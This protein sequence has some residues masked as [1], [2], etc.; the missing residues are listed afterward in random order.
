MADSQ[1][2]PESISDAVAP[3][4]RSRRRFLTSMAA[5]GLVLPS[6]GGWSAARAEDP[7]GSP[8]R[9][10]KLAWNAG[11]ACLS[12]VALADRDNIFDTENLKVELVNFSGSTDQLLESIATGKADAAVGM[13]L[14]WLKPL[15]QGFDVKITAGLHGG[16]LRL[17]GS[18][19]AGAVDLTSLKGKTIAVADMGSPAKNFFSVMLVKQG[20]D[21]VKD[22]EW[23]QYPGNLLGLAIEKGEAHALADNDPITWP[24]RKDPNLVELATNL[25][26]EYHDRTC[27][28]IGIRGSLLR[29]N[30][31]A[32]ARLTRALFHAWHVTAAAPEAAAAAFAPYAPKFSQGDL[33]EM[34]HSHN[35]QQQVIGDTLRAQIVQYVEELKVAQVFKPTTDAAKFAQRVT[36]DVPV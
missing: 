27:C 26:G 35:H 36:A 25:T 3:V 15:E 5:A 20:I 21:P 8:G 12:A 17:F 1:H 33:V 22:V 4:D 32:A 23:R 9:P 14:R 7:I 16:C 30:K 11:A 2:R 13:A 18:R 24:Y 31:E 19:A 6:L 29:E 28:L 10:L 34:L